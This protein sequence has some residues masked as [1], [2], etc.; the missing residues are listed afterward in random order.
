VSATILKFPTRD[1]QATTGRLGSSKPAE[2]PVSLSSR[3]TN[4]SRD[5]PTSIKD[6]LLRSKSVRLYRE[7]LAKHGYPETCG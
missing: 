7:F 6:V 1:R 2:P 4:R 3:T 5:R